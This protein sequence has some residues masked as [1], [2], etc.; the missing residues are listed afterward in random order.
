MKKKICWL[1]LIGSLLISI[2]VSDNALSACKHA[3]NPNLDWV[4]HFFRDVICDYSTYYG[5][6]N[7]LYVGGALFTAGVSANTNIDRSINRFWQQNVKGKTSNKL[8]D[9]FEHIGFFAYSKPYIASTV[10]GYWR[11]NTPVGN[12]LYHWGYKSFR[13]MILASPQVTLLR[14]VLGAGRPCSSKYSDSK[15]RLFTKS[16]TSVSGHTFN[17]AIPFLTAAMMTD[18]PLYK[19]GLYFISILPA[20]SRINDR[21]HYFSQVFLGW[22]LAYLSVKVVDFADQEREQAVKMEI[23]PIKNGTML[24]ARFEF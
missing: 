19:Y 17:G 23:M 3:D 11:I 22:S 13:A 12:W 9:P 14:N 1:P 7:L 16:R 8:L 4:R 18:N 2:A 15:W 10:L 5:T 20:V 24:Q 21:K 6:E